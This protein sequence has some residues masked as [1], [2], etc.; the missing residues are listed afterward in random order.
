MDYCFFTHTFYFTF[1]ALN[2]VELASGVI[3]TSFLPVGLTFLSSDCRC[4]CVC[5]WHGV[6]GISGWGNYVSRQTVCLSGLPA[7]FFNWAIVI[8]YRMVARGELFGRIGSRT[9]CLRLD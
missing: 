7:S 2:S 5:L 6:L 4:G 9:L 8:R 1:Y 3:V